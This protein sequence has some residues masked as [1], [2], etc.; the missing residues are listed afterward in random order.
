MSL[1][2]THLFTKRKKG[3]SKDKNN[4]T[5]S[6]NVTKELTGECRVVLSSEFSISP[7]LH[8]YWLYLAT[9]T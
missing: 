3:I 5:N 7:A 6:R 8:L 9:V 2:S 1:A 4:T